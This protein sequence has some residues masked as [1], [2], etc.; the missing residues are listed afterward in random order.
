MLT[1]LRKHSKGWLAYTAF[2]AIIVV[3]ILWGGSSYL[4]REANKVAK[5][6]RH[7][8]SVEQFQ[9]AYADTL[10]MYYKQFGEA[11]TPDMIERLGLRD[12][13]VDQMINDYIIEVDAKKMGIKVT[14]ADLQQAISRFPGFQRDGRFDEALYRRFLEYERMSPPEFEQKQRKAL[15]TQLFKAVITE[16]LT[17]PPR[18][19]E[20]SYHFLNDAFDLSYIPIDATSFAKDVQVS[21][22]Q[23][24]AYF[25][26]NKDRYRIPPKI[27]LKVL[28]FPAASYMAS[29]EVTEAD[30][31]DYYDGHASEF[32]GP[33]MIHARHILLKVPQ[34]ADPKVQAE[35][36]ALAKKIVSEVHAGKDFAKLAAQYSEDEKT[37]R[38]G[39]DMGTLPPEGFPQ[40]V[41]DVL[42]TMK[43]GEI[44]GPVM[45]QFGL[46][47]LKLEGREEAKATPFE[48]VSASVMD[49][50]K[51]QRAKMT[52]RQE[53]DKAYMELYEQP[54]LDLEGYA[55]A[56]GLT[57]RQ[58]GPF[59]DGQDAGITMGPEAVKKAFTFSPGELGEV[60]STSGGFFI[61]TVAAKDQSRVPELKEVM[62]RVV[63]DLKAKTAMQKAK[64]Y[65]KKLAAS[66]SE[67]RTAMNPSST[68]EFRR[69]SNAVPKLSML[70]K[71]MDE[72][73]ALATPKVFETA[74]TVYIVWLK[75]K[76]TAD[77]R[78][79]DMK[80]KDAIMKELYG[81]KQQVALD[82]YLEQAWKRHDVVKD[83]ERLGKGGGSSRDVPAPDDF[84]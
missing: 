33:A 2:G 25:D 75:S 69:T 51:L 56:K 20:A 57:I 19:I 35:K 72:L 4:A 36:E 82:A 59:S 14:D 29:T 11:L 26:A 21:Q 46:H 55:K 79:M 53:A 48:Q 50:L 41:G 47:I 68:G 40:G 7:V 84:N 30:A 17:V 45:S 78:A 81:R 65:A 31:R 83:Q 13:V 61:Y 24:Q 15:L 52:A 62:D 37:A 70:P 73:D 12:K 22:E 42:A 66:S 80:T 44:K 16:N 3:F 77:V 60:V 67:Q 8:I 58:V 10:K 64:E 34:G 54:K 27:T 76:G 32:S 1:Y 71:L 23:V 18:E 39:G 28:E 5:V 43:Q 9:K 74:G 38:K 63:A 49:T 6:D